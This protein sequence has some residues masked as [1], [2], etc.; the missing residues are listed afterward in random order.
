[1]LLSPDMLLCV[2]SDAS[3]FHWSSMLAQIPSFEKDLDNAEQHH[4]PLPFPSGSS[5]SFSFNFFY[6]RK[7]RLSHI[8]LLHSSGTSAI[9]TFRIHSLH[10]RQKLDFQFQ[11][12]HRQWLYSAA[13]SFQNTAVGNKYV[14]I[15]LWN[16]TYPWRTKH[17]SWYA[18]SIGRPREDARSSSPFCTFKYSSSTQY[19]AE[20]RVGKYLRHVK[21]TGEI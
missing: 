15:H 14:V 7:G 19:G 6:T 17:L 11:S 21:F 10:R 2:L 4:E 8:H 1:M 5:N 13:R 18:F 16:C 20:I 12:H 3:E 9:S